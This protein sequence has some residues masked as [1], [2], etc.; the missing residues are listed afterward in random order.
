MCCSHLLHKRLRTNV[1]INP[2]LFAERGVSL[3]DIQCL[4]NSD[5][6][7]DSLFGINFDDPSLSDHDFFVLT[8]LKKAQFDEV[9]ASAGLKH[10]DTWSPRNALGV[11]L[12]KLRVGLSHRELSILFRVPI[13]KIHTRINQTRERLIQEGGFVE[14]NLGV[15]ALTREELIH[16]HTT[17]VAKALYG[18]DKLILVE[19]ATYVYTQ[20]SSNYSFARSTFCV[21]KS[22]YC[23]K[24][25][26]CV[27]TDGYYVDIFGPYLSNQKNTDACIFQQQFSDSVEADTQGLKD[28]LHDGDI[29]IVDRGF[30][31][32]EKY[33][34][35]L[36]VHM[37]SFHEDGDQIEQPPEPVGNDD[38]RTSE[39]TAAQSGQ[40][41]D[42]GDG[43]T[44]DSED[45]EP[46]T[47]KS[48]SR[49]TVKSTSKKIKRSKPKKKKR[50]RRKQHSTADANKS[51]KVTKLRYVVECANGRLKQFKFLARVVSNTQIRF[52]GDYCRIGA[53][54]IN[55]FRPPLATSKPHHLQ[56]AA[57]M[58]AKL[59]AHNKLME[60]C[61]QG[62]RL[63]SKSVAVWEPLEASHIPGFPVLTEAEIAEH[64]TFG[65][66]QI[67]Q[68]RS[69]MDEHLNSRG[70]CDFSR[71]R[72]GDDDDNRVVHVKVQSRHKSNVVYR[73][74]VE[75]DTTKSMPWEK[76]TGWYCTC[77][78]GAR[79]MGCCA[80]V[81]TVIW[82]LGVGRRL[83]PRRKLNLWQNVMDASG[84]VHQEP[85]QNAVITAESLAAAEDSATVT[86]ADSS[87]VN[88]DEIQKPFQT[89]NEGLA[90]VATPFSSA[91]ELVVEAAVIPR[92]PRS[93]TR[94]GATTRTR[95][96]RSQAI[97]DVDNEPDVPDD[98][99]ANSLLSGIKASMSTI[100]LE[101]TFEQFSQALAITDQEMRKALNIKGLLHQY[102][103]TTNADIF[104]HAAG[105]TEIR[106]NHLKPLLDH[107]FDTGLMWLN[108]A[109]VDAYVGMIQ[110]RY[111][112]VQ[113][114]PSTFWKARQN[115]ARVRQSWQR[116]MDNVAGRPVLM[117]PVLIPTQQDNVD[118]GHWVLALVNLERKVC[119]VL[120][121]LGIDRHDVY[122][123][124][125]QL[126]PAA[127]LNLTYEKRPRNIIQCDTHSC[128]ALVLMAAEMLASGIELQTP[129]QPTSNQ[130]SCFRCKV[131]L[132][133]CERIII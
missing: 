114:L 23:V 88:C 52:I 68:A 7:D 103:S 49:S 77:T 18:H 124:L 46:S 47:R 90:Q 51:R 67:R 20:K 1:V 25:M 65:K 91:V 115:H 57:R 69:Y 78:S 106:V 24:P 89:S 14:K 96:T 26:V 119:S 31:G 3:T 133:I 40:D 5:E 2:S 122:Q 60:Q 10:S 59:N 97:V 82:W 61:V 54:L 22:R 34:P 8:G 38:E 98:P 71:S 41:S 75:F 108:S 62:G 33:V 50:A 87:D 94:V 39:T 28:F 118:T 74:F 44:S 117:F 132:S 55:K 95:S 130:I 16:K 123:E 27:T 104:L 43:D 102:F 109:I 116:V 66:Y 58:L 45:F 131:L 9:V 72:Y 128:G 105:G 13:K 11:L 21:H 110:A 121:T 129:R 112:N 92:A 120:D 79:T 42:E 36:E 56:L 99:V 101:T 107:P 17:D 53:A 29:W 32:A 63:H 37:P 48:K 83:E 76:I 127:S 100:T 70:D 64:I 85:W 81:T 93:E 4:I 30:K 113:T 84:V 86:E 12:V 80:H 126:E 35:H 111:S 125:V 73:T 15:K 19:D 6:R